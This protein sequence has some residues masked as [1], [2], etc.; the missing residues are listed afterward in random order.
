M[1]TFF[2]QD[3]ESFYIYIDQEIINRLKNRVFK[4]F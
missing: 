4:I 3:E 1:N 2:D